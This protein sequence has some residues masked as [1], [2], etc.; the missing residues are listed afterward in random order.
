MRS[1]VRAR[2]APPNFNHLQTHT[3]NLGPLLVQNRRLAGGCLTLFPAQRRVAP[4]AARRSH[5]SEWVPLTL[6]IYPL[7]RLLLGS[8]VGGFAMRSAGLSLIWGNPGA[9]ECWC[10]A[11]WTNGAK[12]VETDQDGPG[13][14]QQTWPHWTNR[15]DKRVKTCGQT[16]QTAQISAY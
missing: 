2:L 3:F 16:G 5:L 8:R 15:S 4:I 1:S 7:G 13:S 9:E 10:E 14:R 11:N 12:E 6:K